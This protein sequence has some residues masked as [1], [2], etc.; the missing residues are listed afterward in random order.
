[1]R[2]VLRLVRVTC[3]AVG[4][5]PLPILV[6]GHAAPALAAPEP[7]ADK[8]MLVLPVVATRL[9]IAGELHLR[10]LESHL[11]NNWRHRNGNPLLPRD[12]AP[13]G[14]F[15]RVTFSSDTLP[16]SGI[17]RANIVFVEQKLPH[18]LHMPHTTGCFSPQFGTVGWYPFTR[19]PLGNALQ[20]IALFHV[21]PKDPLDEGGFVRINDIVSALTLVLDVPIA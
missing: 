14:L 21:Q 20:R 1:V 7:P 3:T 6:A 9:R 18:T 2:D 15:V 13:V 5:H 16:L 12:S 17:Q 4:T 8:Q 11:V 10:G 19:Q